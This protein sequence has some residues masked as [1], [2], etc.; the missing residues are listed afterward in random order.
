M[1]FGDME[2]LGQSIPKQIVQ[3]PTLEVIILVYNKIMGNLIKA[4][5][6]GIQINKSYKMNVR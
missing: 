2:M 4:N 5:N 3:L 6:D 1:E